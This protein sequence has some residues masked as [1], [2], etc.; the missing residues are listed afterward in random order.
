MR[1]CL[2]ALIA[3]DRHHLSLKAAHKSI[4]VSLQPHPNSRSDNISMGHFPGLWWV[5][6]CF[7]NRTQRTSI[8]ISCS[9]TFLGDTARKNSLETLGA[10]HGATRLRMEAKRGVFEKLTLG[11]LARFGCGKRGA[12]QAETPRNLSLKHLKHLE[13]SRNWILKIIKCM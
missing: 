8:L 5:F 7:C 1:L 6:F 2:V 12:K 13:T 4:Q 10:T 11:R 3:P 9:L